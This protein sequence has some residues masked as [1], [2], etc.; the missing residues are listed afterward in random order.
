MCLSM[1]EEPAHDQFNDQVSVWRLVPTSL[2]IYKRE[3]S[4]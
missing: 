3:W 2:R 1:K 4:Y